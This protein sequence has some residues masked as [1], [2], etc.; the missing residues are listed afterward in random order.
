MGFDVSITECGI[1]GE[2][3]PVT[4]M[5]DRSG[6][7]DLMTRDGEGDIDIHG[8]ARFGVRQILSRGPDAPTTRCALH[9]RNRRR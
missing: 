9:G 4:Y 3:F 2:D 7:G 8:L 5:A 1:H 6:L